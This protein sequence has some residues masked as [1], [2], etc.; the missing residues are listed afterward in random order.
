MIIHYQ[1]WIKINQYIQQTYV[2]TTSS[3]P[4]LMGFLFLNSDLNA[5]KNNHTRE[6]LFVIKSKMKPEKPTDRSTPKTGNAWPRLWVFAHSAAFPPACPSLSAW[7]VWALL[8][9]AWLGRP[10]PTAL[11]PFR[12]APA[13]PESTSCERVKPV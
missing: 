10:P 9:L 3:Y 5:E 4:V 7:D 1:Y 11:F 13:L 2:R 12:D 6:H 8:R